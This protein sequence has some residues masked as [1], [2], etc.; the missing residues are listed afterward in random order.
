MLDGEWRARHHA[1]AVVPDRR[2][3]RSLKFYRDQIR[4][5]VPANAPKVTWEVSQ[6]GTPSTVTAAIGRVVGKIGDKPDGPKMNLTIHLPA[7]ASG[8][9]PL[10]LSITFG[11]GPRGQVPANAAQAAEKAVPKKGTPPVIFDALGECLAQGWGLLR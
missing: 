10:V 4:G 3:R 2:S 11:M 5:H 6:A 8:P 7:K 9:V 1:R